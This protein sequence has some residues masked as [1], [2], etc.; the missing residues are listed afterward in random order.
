MTGQTKTNIGAQFHTAKY[1]D[2]RAI[3]VLSS[4][5]EKTTDKPGFYI[6]AAG[7]GVIT[8]INL[9]KGLDPF[10]SKVSEFLIE[11]GILIIKQPRL[12]TEVSWNG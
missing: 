9:L 8:D 11:E 12:N 5:T 2:Q 10:Y 3:N 1:T 6:S 4:R 7:K